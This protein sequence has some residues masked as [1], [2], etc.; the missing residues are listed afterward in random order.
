ML[1]SE[2]FT[3]PKSIGMLQTSFHEHYPCRHCAMDD[4][5]E[6]D[7][8]QDLQLPELVQEITSAQMIERLERIVNEHEYGRLIHV[9][10][11]PVLT[12]QA[13]GQPLITNGLERY[14]TLWKRMRLVVFLDD[15]DPDDGGFLELFHVE[16]NADPVL[17]YHVPPKRGRMVFF[18][19]HPFVYVGASPVATGKRYR[20][21]SLSFYTHETPEWYM[22]GGVE[23][24]M[25]RPEDE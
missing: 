25:E 20:A 21:L 24:R 15:W 17:R 9:P 6:D 7:V 5:L 22:A 18:E 1:V 13:V 19:T 12:V 10:K 2:R 16:P 14:G 11:D 3:D 23:T 8:L 4:F